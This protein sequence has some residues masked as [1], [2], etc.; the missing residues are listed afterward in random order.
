MYNTII[1]GHICKDINID[2]EGNEV[3]MCGGAVTYASAAAKAMGHRVA[4][5]TR[6]GAADSEIVNEF[7]IPKED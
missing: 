2:C 6:I 1:I 3:R 5:V 4:A 7:I